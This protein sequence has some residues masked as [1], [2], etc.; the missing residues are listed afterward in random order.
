LLPGQAKTKDQPAVSQSGV[1]TWPP[2]TEENEKSANSWRR[3][4]A[5]KANKSQNVYQH[6]SLISAVL[7]L[8]MLQLFNSSACF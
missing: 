6:Q 5:N 1:K 3:F 7:D 2:M 4:F 8:E